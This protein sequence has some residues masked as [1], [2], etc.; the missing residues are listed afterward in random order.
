MS[1]GYRPARDVGTS[2]G[3]GGGALVINQRKRT[4]EIENEFFFDLFNETIIYI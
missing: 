1:G 2:C 3:A 4:F